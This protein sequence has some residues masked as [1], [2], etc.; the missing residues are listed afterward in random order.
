MSCNTSFCFMCILF[1]TKKKEYIVMA[2]LSR[3]ASGH[4]TIR[5][6]KKSI[7]AQFHTSWARKGGSMI[8]RWA[9]TPLALIPS[10]LWT[11]PLHSSRGTLPSELPK[12]S[13]HYQINWAFQWFFRI[14]PHSRQLDPSLQG[15]ASLGRAISVLEYPFG[16]AS[17]YVL[18]A[19]PST[20]Q[21]VILLPSWWSAQ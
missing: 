10:S 15:S 6:S 1:Y 21:P 12:W 18:H 5:L 9:A 4:K 14:T 3:M 7:S 8:V 17:L 16:G 2:G 20:R 19:P 13:I 11:I